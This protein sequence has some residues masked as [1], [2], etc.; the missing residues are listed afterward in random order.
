MSQS[1]TT[2]FADLRPSLNVSGR[3][4]SAAI[5]LSSWL[6]RTLPINEILRSAIRAGGYSFLGESKISSARSAI[7]PPAPGGR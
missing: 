5:F 4:S 3:I 6:T 7:A 1:S 2:M